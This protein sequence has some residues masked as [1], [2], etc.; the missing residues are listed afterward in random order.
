MS[1]QLQ[2]HGIKGMKWGVRRFQPYQKGKTVKGGKEVGKAKKVTNR[3]LRK[4]RALQ[5]TK[6]V[7]TVMK[8]LEKDFNEELQEAVK[9]NDTQKVSDMSNRLYN[10]SPVARAMTTQEMTTKYG[11]ERMDKLN[12]SDVRRGKMATAARMSVV[13]APAAVTLG[14]LIYD[15]IS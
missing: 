9:D 7:K 8:Q 10:P 3:A 2:H 12:K 4:E 6:N 1:D 15:E 5:D 11:Q 14:A 13:I